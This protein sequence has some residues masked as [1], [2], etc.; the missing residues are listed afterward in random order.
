MT[1]DLLL[2]ADGNNLPEACLKEKETLY[3]AVMMRKAKLCE[4]VEPRIREAQDLDCPQQEDNQVKTIT[5]KEA[6]GL[7]VTKSK[8]GSEPAP[9]KW[10]SEIGGEIGSYYAD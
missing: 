1:V 8:A 3:M 9:F 2:D 6:G 7:T 10:E 4:V 5:R